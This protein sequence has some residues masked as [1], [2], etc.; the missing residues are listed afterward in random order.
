MQND[1]DVIYKLLNE[2]G[3]LYLAYTKLILSLSTG[4]IGLLTTF[5]NNWVSDGDSYIVI[6]QLALTLFLISFFSGLVL[7]HQHMVRPNQLANKVL[8]QVAEA[9]KS[10]KT[11]A[12]DLP[13]TPSRIE[14][15]S[16]KC[17]IYT[18]YPAVLM[19]VLYVVTNI[20][21]P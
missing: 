12:I 8:D 9:V 10:G 21:N 2:H 5:R 3:D 20:N 1:R 16:Y 13:H 14:Q 17:Q 18:F 19:V 4:A 6:A 7:Q 11:S 15:I